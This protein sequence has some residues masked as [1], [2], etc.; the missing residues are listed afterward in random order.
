MKVLIPTH[1][2]SGNRGCE[3]ISR[4]TE[5][6]L[7]KQYDIIEYSSDIELDNRICDFGNEIK[8]DCSPCFIRKILYKVGRRLVVTP[9]KKGMLSVKE[10]CQYFLKD[11]KLYDKKVVLSTGGDMFCYDNN[12]VVW[13]NDYLHENGVKTVLWGCSI[14]KE[15]LTP[16]KEDTLKKFSLI[17][18]RETITER[19]LKEEVHLENVKMFPDP[20][21]VLEAQKID[22][23]DCFEGRKIVGI[24]LS[25]FVGQDV[26][27]ST[28]FGRNLLKLMDYII[29]QT[30]MDVVL[31]PHVFWDGQDDRRICKLVY[32]KYA[33]TKRVH[34]LNTEGLNYSQIRYV[35]SNCRFFIGARTHAMISA[36]STCVPSL[37][38]GYSVKS[39]GIARDIG[40]PDE[41]VVN[42]KA[43]KMDD[44]LVKAFVYLLEHENDIRNILLKNIPEYK[45]RAYE[46]KGALDALVEG[47]E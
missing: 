21:F 41:L 16:E 7:S 44:E 30:T 37:A 27:F 38:L 39:V 29:G 34:Y 13:L 6:I 46:A 40:M 15:N 2:N 5:A 14:G 3:A 45:N 1:F 19:L 10:H 24:N 17:T 42:Y 32:D 31:I 22:L 11:L 33:E 23:P 18:A 47:I 25:N 12:I 9:R 35:I 36:Y 8:R 43:L 20:A 28:P 4:G 26:G